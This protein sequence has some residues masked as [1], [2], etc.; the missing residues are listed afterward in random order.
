MW[1][2]MFLMIILIISS[3]VKSCSCGAVQRVKLHSC[4]KSQ[5][6]CLITSDK[7]IKTSSPVIN[8]RF[9]D[10]DDLYVE[11]DAANP[12]TS[13]GDDMGLSN[14]MVNPPKRQNISDEEEDAGV[15]LASVSSSSPASSRGPGGRRCRSVCGGD[16]P[17]F[18]GENVT[19][20]SSVPLIHTN[21]PVAIS[22]PEEN[23]KN[24]CG[25]TRSV[26]NSKNYVPK[27]NKN[28]AN[29]IRESNK[30]KEAIRQPRPASCTFGTNG[31]SET[32]LEGKHKILSR[33]GR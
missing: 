14:N 28:S 9:A 17:T 15:C 23:R 1:R 18:H 2:L 29:N 11:V 21:A 31:A 20:D 27:F 24:K 3:I 12:Q 16:I 8:G 13:G 33:R 32:T 4:L 5:F 22:T 30:R 25:S 7:D 6:S 10:E 19:K 26:A